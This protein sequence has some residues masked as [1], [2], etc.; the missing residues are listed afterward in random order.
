MHQVPEPKAA[1]SVLGCKVN[2]TEA[3]AITEMFRRAGYKIVDFSEQADVY[4][5]HTCTVTGESD[6]KSRNLIRRA[7]KQNPDAVVAVTGCYA[8][9][10]PKSVQSIDGV[11][12]IVGTG[13]IDKIVERVQDARNGKRQITAV[14]SLSELPSFENF[15]QVSG[16]VRAFLKVQEGCQ[17][18]CTYCI[19]PYARGP[20]RSR[21]P[22]ETLKRAKELAASG[23]KEIVVTGIRLGA[24]GQDLQPSVSL[25][26]LVKVLAGVPGLERLRISSVDPNDFSADLVSVVIDSPV[27]CPHYHIPLQSGDDT[28]LSRMGRRYSSQQYLELIQILRA[29]RPLA[30]FT[31]DVMVGFPG[32]T[33]K[34]FENTK[35]VIESAKFMGV[36]VF[37]YSA[38]KGTPA[39]EYPEQ[40]PHELKVRRSKEIAT[41]ADKMFIDYATQFLNQKTEVLVE[42]R[43]QQGL[44]EG[45]TPNYLFVK[46]SSEKDHRN[47]IVPVRITE[48]GNNFVVGEGIL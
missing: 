40:I 2:Q 29:R 21:P 1:V 47:Q 27:V 38:R 41:L 42:Q 19:I 16:R 18:F 6:K 11:D 4:I 34:Q 7:V 23:F 35:R 32:E 45:H 22:D 8:Q 37:K 48:I 31:T 5:I 39:A 3:E 13:N 33:D 17:Q 43:D 10:S 44:W 15:P 9:V 25:A 26:G 36:H 28:V 12:V 14:S 24:Y 30:A 46:F 20:V